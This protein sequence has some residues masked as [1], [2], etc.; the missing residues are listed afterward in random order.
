MLPGG[1]NGVA[2]GEREQSRK[3]RLCLIT[4]W[5]KGRPESC[6]AACGPAPESQQSLLLLHSPLPTQHGE[7]GTFL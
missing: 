5:K 4:D 2:D 3:P 6:K 7:K 1:N